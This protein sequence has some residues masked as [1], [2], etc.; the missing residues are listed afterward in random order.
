LLCATIASIFEDN[1]PKGELRAMAL[2]AANAANTF[3]EHLV[4]YIGNK[5]SLVAL[6]KL[7]SK[8]TLLFLSNKMVKKIAMTSL[9]IKATHPMCM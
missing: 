4:V 2:Q 1:L 9:S 7:L 6:F 3:G 8:H 5:Y